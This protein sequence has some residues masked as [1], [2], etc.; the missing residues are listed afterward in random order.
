MSRIQNMWEPSFTLFVLG[1]RVGMLGRRDGMC[2]DA[3]RIF[4]NPKP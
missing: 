1:R 3:G 2:V 4:M